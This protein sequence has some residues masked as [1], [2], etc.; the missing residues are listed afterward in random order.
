MNRTLLRINLQV[1]PK[2]TP[3][4]T[5][6][7]C[8]PHTDAKSGSTVAMASQATLTQYNVN[9]PKLAYGSILQAGSWV[10]WCNLMFFLLLSSLLLRFYV[11]C[12]S[13]RRRLSAGNAGALIRLRSSYKVLIN[14]YNIHG[15]VT[16]FNWNWPDFV[17]QQ[18]P[19]EQ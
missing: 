13:L 16:L 14:M 10:Y 8:F 2:S 12:K 3:I 6:S 18:Y 11:S 15:R 19:S 17:Y 5:H 7:D 4:Q 1:P 9:S